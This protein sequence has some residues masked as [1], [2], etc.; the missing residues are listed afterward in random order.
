MVWS[1]YWKKILLFIL[2]VNSWNG[3]VAQKDYVIVDKPNLRLYV[4][5]NTDTVFNVPVCVGKNWGNKVK[6]GDNRTPE[7]EFTI[8]EI[9]DSRQ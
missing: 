2:T 7:G 9:Q 5:E 1:S 3:I 6:V 4:I 8:C